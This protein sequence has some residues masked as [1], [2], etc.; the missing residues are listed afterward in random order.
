MPSEKIVEDWLKKAEEDCGFGAFNLKDPENPFYA[1]I[2]FHFQQAAEKY[3]K[4]Y[5]VASHLEFR[6]IHD[7]PQLMQ[8][9]SAHNSSFSILHEECDFLTDFYVDTRYP[10]HWPSE[11]TREEAEKARECAC[12]I[13]DFVKSIIENINRR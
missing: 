9:C 3:L 12:K 4:A 2:C 11:V 1:Q 6:K 10:V 7:L 5:I 8:I 13:G